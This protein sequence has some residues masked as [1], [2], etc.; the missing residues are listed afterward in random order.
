MKTVRKWYSGDYYLYL[1]DFFNINF[2]K[3]LLILA[4]I[5]PMLAANIKDQFNTIMRNII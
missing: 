2:E 1:N 4:K 3:K 5:L